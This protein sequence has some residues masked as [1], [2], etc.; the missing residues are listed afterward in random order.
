MPE[1]GC[2]TLIC[3]RKALATSN[4]PPG[5]MEGP[6]PQQEGAAHAAAL[7]ESQR[8]TSVMVLNLTKSSEACTKQIS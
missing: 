4:G 3:E 8:L 6:Q 7:A 1:E 5:V 2:V